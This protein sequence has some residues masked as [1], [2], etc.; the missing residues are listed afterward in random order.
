MFINIVIKLCD[1]S[2]LIHD[3]IRS[4]VATATVHCTASTAY[5]AIVS[6]SFVIIFRSRTVTRKACTPTTRAI[7]TCN[8]SE[9]ISVHATLVMDPSPTPCNE[10]RMK[11]RRVI[12]IPVW[13]TLSTVVRHALRSCGVRSAQKSV[14]PP[15]AVTAES[16][17]A[18]AVIGIMGMV[19]GMWKRW[20][21][22]TNAWN[23]RQKPP[24]T[25]TSRARGS[26]RRNRSAIYTPDTACVAVDA[27]HTDHRKLMLH[28]EGDEMGV[29]VMTADDNTKTAHDVLCT[30]RRSSKD[31]RR[32]K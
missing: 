28:S 31:D 1:D 25:K 20:I 2:H 23:A 27:S 8:R 30:Q 32:G 16:A 17:A 7:M 21:A 4:K 11:A 3:G 15:R 24:W 26:A 19:D 12:S 13:A 22:T 10:S 6:V 5:V 9:F 18:V 29:T 14:A